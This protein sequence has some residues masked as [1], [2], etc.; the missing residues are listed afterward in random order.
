MLQRTNIE[1]ILHDVKAYLS[2][3][4]DKLRMRLP[5]LSKKCATSTTLIHSV[6]TLGTE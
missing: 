3:L 5:H 4:D 6:Y 2:E 1:G